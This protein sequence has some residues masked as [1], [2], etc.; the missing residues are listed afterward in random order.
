M[1]KIRD[2]K[3][4][5]LCSAFIHFLSYK[6]VKTDLDTRARKTY[7][8]FGAVDLMWIHRLLKPGF[9]H[10]FVFYETPDGV[11]QVEYLANVVQVSTI[12]HSRNVD[13]YLK[14][15]L[16]LGY[17][18]LECTF[19]PQDIVCSYVPKLNPSNCVSLTKLLLGMK[20]PRTYTPW[21]LY[22]RLLKFR[23]TKEIKHGHK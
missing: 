10:C 14:V 18:I 4:L 2:W 15:L 22:N 19:S 8:A 7:V 1:G 12:P 21:Q 6:R 13:R 9:Q 3:P 23:Q 5:S 16:R 17:R 20:L 11:I